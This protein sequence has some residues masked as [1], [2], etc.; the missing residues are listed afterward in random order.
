MADIKQLWPGNVT[1]DCLT[2]TMKNVEGEVRKEVSNSEEG[3]EVGNQD[4]KVPFARC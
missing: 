3:F 1:T 2:D 4:L